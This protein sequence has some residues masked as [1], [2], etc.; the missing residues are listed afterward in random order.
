MM[1]LESNLR[2]PPSTM[3]FH[4]CSQISGAKRL[5]FQREC[6]STCTVNLT[7]GDATSLCFVSEVATFNSPF[8]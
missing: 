1:R 8:E 2:C 7:R 4:M 6:Q 5:A 3:L